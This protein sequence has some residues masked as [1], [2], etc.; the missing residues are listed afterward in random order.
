[1]NILNTADWNKILEESYFTVKSFLHASTNE[2][3]KEKP[4]DL[5][6]KF[7]IY[8]SEELFFGGS[9]GGSKSSALLMSAL[10]FVTQP[11][12]D[13]LI[14]R[15]TYSDL[16]QPNSIMD[17]CQKWLAQPIEDKKVKFDKINKKF[18]FPS[19]ATLSFGYL[20]NDNDLNTYQGAELQ[21]IGIDEA[22]Q[23][24][25]K[26]IRYLHSRLRKTKD[27]PIPLRIRYTG[28]PGGLSNDYFRDTFVNGD[29]PFIPSRYTDNPYL[30]TKEYE[31]QL[32]QLDEYTKQQLKYGNWDVVL[33]SGLLISVDDL[34]KHVIDG[35]DD[36]SERLFSVVGI[37]PAGSGQDKFAISLIGYYSNNRMLVED[38]QST[39]N[40]NQEAILLDFLQHH[41]DKKIQFLNFEREPGS[42]S[43]FALKYWQGVVPHIRCVDTPASGS[44]FVRA[45]P[46][47]MAIK[48]D[49]LYFKSD[50]KLLNVLF[51]QFQYV[52]P[53]KNKM[54]EYSSPDEL[55]S[56]GYGYNG[57][58]SLL[59]RKRRMRII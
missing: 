45:R 57:L 15:K 32:N 17:R 18:T 46:V 37:D 58:L 2:Y 33:N 19:G 29:L 21:F 35:F 9:A 14:I 26:Q 28:N 3:I 42:S 5:Q 11:N 23:L 12:Y 51:N 44:K 55:D 25:E 59:N 6:W 30:N 47:A 40:T 22:T 13:A 16:S 24:T 31:K 53:D 27:N 49:D 20:S 39:Q 52:H 43:D 38:I 48:N 4:F 7:L 1:M 41:E 36:G 34:K 54:K 10:T 56:L 50:I 8:P